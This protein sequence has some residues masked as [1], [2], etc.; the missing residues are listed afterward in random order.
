[1]FIEKIEIKN[2]AG[3]DRTIPFNHRLTPIY[4]INGCGKTTMLKILYNTLNMKKTALNKLAFDNCRIFLSSGIKLNA[5]K[6]GEIGITSNDVIKLRQKN[7]Q[8]I[9]FKVKLIQGNYPIYLEKLD[10]SQLNED[11]KKLFLDIINQ[12]LDYKQL[13][14][15]LEIILPD[16]KKLDFEHLSSGEKRLI[17]Y[18][19][20][21]ASIENAVILMD[22]PEKSLHITWSRFFTRDIVKFGERNNLQFIICTHSVE[23]V[24]DNW[25]LNVNLN[26]C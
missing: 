21:I 22:N 3:K 23:I 13:N 17:A 14:D 5:N 10:G 8:S 24:S 19:F 6:S 4:G 12:K 9:N 11:Q 2:L 25:D 26:E 15:D 16:G 1:M 18:Y 7:S 20:A